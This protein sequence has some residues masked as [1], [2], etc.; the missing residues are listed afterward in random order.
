MRAAD[1]GHH[2]VDPA[3]DYSRFDVLVEA[4][5][6]RPWDGTADVLRPDHPVAKDAQ[7]A[8]GVRVREPRGHDRPHRVAARP[9]H[10]KGAAHLGRIS[11]AIH[12]GV[13]VSIL[14]GDY[15]SR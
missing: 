8:D 1:V 15:E 14:P 13:Q 11:K 2:A 3:A 7:V 10:A 12:R 6:G 4:A 5:H 9:A